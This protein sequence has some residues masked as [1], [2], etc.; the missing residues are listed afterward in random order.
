MAIS[1]VDFKNGV[2]FTGGGNAD[3]VVFTLLGGRYGCAV[4]A[5]WGGGNVQL[6]I[7]MPDGTTYIN[8]AASF[9]A[10]GT[11]VYDLPQ[12]KFKILVTTAS[13]VQGSLVPIP[14]RSVV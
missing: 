6:Q 13:A 11:A 3:A 10:D 2:T 14:Y 9:T 5:T 1:V 7:L 12:G 8:A 4:N